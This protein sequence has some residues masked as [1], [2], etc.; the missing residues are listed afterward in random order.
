MSTAIVSYI[1]DS[2]LQTHPDQA[3][4]AVCNRV[5]AAAIT[6]GSLPVMS[7]M[8]GTP[9]MSVALLSPPFNPSTTPPARAM[10]HE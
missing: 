9:G 6:S 2:N 5:A 3:L 10:N 7:V 4:P 1:L 8:P